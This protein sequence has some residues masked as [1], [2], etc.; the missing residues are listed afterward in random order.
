MTCWD[1]ALPS[2]TPELKITN[3]SE[4]LRVVEVPKGEDTLYVCEWY[5]G[6]E[7]RSLKEYYDEDKAEEWMV[8]QMDGMYSDDDEE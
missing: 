3:M 1:L 8:A 5:C 6:R 2:D 7:W 4:T